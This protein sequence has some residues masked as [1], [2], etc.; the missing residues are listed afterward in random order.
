MAGF[1]VLF[2]GENPKADDREKE[3]T[4]VLLPEFFMEML[5]YGRLP[6]GSM[7]DI[8]RVYIRQGKVLHHQCSLG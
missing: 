7:V 4:K 6:G 2:I 3:V 8:D 5:G 1:F